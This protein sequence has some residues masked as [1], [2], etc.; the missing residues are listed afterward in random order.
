MSLIFIGTFFN[1]AI[2]LILTSANTQYTIIDWIP[3]R[4]AYTDL[5]EDWYIDMGDALVWT[6]L[7]NALNPYISI[8]ISFATVTLARS[9]DQG[10]FNYICCRHS[11]KTK[12]KTI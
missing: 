2:L 10:C 11:K 8:S 3:L 4:G 7:V 6:L 12:Q 9:L 1:T 5:D